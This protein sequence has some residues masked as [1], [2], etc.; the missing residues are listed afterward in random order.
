MENWKQARRDYEEKL[1][2]SQCR[3]HEILLKK[4]TNWGIV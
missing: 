3:K 1:K 4:Y 2:E